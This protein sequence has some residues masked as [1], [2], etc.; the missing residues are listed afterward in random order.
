MISYDSKHVSLMFMN[1]KFLF[2]SSV[3]SAPP[4]PINVIFSS[5]NLRNTLQW[6]PGNGTPDDTHFTVQYAM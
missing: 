1:L 6:V 3:S 5:V 2:S 4:S